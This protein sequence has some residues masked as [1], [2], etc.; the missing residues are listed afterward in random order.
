MF[1]YVL[2]RRVKVH[3]HG[4]RCGNQTFVL[5]CFYNDFLAYILR[6]NLSLNLELINL[7]KC[8]PVN[9]RNPHIS[10]SPVLGIEISLYA[11]PFLSLP[12]C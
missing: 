9:L 6:Q 8:W 5:G 3:M 1:V 12:G 4:S 10:A 7:I 11:L 2:G